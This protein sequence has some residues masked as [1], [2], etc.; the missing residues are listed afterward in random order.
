LLVDQ[1]R[2]GQIDVCHIL[3]QIDNRTLSLLQNSNMIQ[4]AIPKLPFIDKALTI[5]FY[6]QQLG[7]E[8]IADYGDYFLIK[9]DGTE[10]HFFAYPELKPDKSDF[11]IY[12]RVKD[13]IE[14]LYAQWNNL[15][16]ALL[17]LGKLELKPWGQKE[18]PLIDPNGTLLTFGQEK[19]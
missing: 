11:M 1:P 5:D 6:I 3:K 15:K 7:F 18:F 12:L 16:P 17:R 10:L 2:K 14:A 4:S 9:L 13:D 8:L 19:V